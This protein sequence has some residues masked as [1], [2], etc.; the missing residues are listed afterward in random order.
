MDYAKFGDDDDNDSIY[1]EV[2]M[3]DFNFSEV[4]VLLYCHFQHLSFIL[5][6][7]FKNSF[8]CAIV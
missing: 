5:E 2:N 6:N 3:D 1:G 8:F 7:C 4:N